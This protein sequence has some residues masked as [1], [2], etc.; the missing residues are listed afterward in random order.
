MSDKPVSAKLRA[1]I[2]AA[3][4]I[5][6]S[7]FILSG[8]TKAID[9]WGFVFKINDYLAV[10]QMPQ[11]HALVL[12]AASAISIAEFIL[13][14]AMATGSYK[15]WAP[16]LLTAI[17]AVMLPLTAYIA[18]ADPVADCGCFGDFLILSNTATLLKNI[19]ITALLVWLLI[20]NRRIPGLYH[21][22][23][24][25]LQTAIA[26]AYILAV[27]AIGYHI[28]PLVDFRPYPE[29]T[30]LALAVSEAQN[31][32]NDA[33]NLVFIYE[34]DGEKREFTTDTLPDSTWTFVDRIEKQPKSASA[35]PITLFDSDGDDVTAEA[36]TGRGTQLLLLIPDMAHTD[37]AA[38]DIIAD[39]GNYVT[40]PPVNGS[41][42]AIL[43]S[44]EPDAA[45]TWTDLA[46]AEYPVYTA[47]DTEI[48]QL[49]RGT[50]SL[51]LL[52]DGTIQWK[53]S[54]SSISPDLMES[55]D[56]DVLQQLDPQSRLTFMLL[57]AIFILAELLLL[58]FDKSSITI[59]HFI[60]RK[61]KKNA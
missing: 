21:P 59:H 61:N 53:R 7:V 1:A 3:R 49:A 40:Q 25:W 37:I 34:K 55:P 10:W 43:P 42:A 23:S 26:V 35:T 60:V 31:S 22:L 16:W 33:D 44:D 32:G 29:G 18:I 51:V 46:M 12:I 2:W 27:A 19:A 47:D 8:I 14:M 5:A 15:R 4:I 38:T 9:I 54:V 17:M 48:K 20:Y 36:I 52:V 11:P 13:G 50:M 28:Q 58:A 57:T 56:T 41:F 39:L 45:E 24:Q 30:N 6:G